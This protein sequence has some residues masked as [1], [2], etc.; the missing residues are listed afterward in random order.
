MT[1]PLAIK[2]HGF[3]DMLYCHFTNMKQVLC[4]LC[5]T[6]MLWIFMCSLLP[7]ALLW[8]HHHSKRRSR[9]ACRRRASLL[10]VNS[11]DEV[12][13]MSHAVTC[14]AMNT[15]RN[16]RN[17]TIHPNQTIWTCPSYACAVFKY[18]CHKNA[19]IGSIS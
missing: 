3:L 17:C 6:I 16:V 10:T 14:V 4:I 2:H 15:L 9:E 11:L 12:M 18:L 5:N 13:H 1:F 8:K 19:S 7:K